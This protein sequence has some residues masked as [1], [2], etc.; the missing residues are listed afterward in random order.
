MGN[1]NFR[2][3]IAA[4]FIGIFVGIIAYDNARDINLEKCQSRADALTDLFL[5]SKEARE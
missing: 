5:E 2:A 3:L 4:L 1:I